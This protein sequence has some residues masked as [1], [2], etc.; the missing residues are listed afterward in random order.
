MT[1]QSNGPVANENYS[2]A[3]GSN[4]S[5]P[6]ITVLM[7]RDPNQYDSQYPVKQR[8]VNTV[9]ATEWILI[10]FSNVTGRTLANWLQLVG[11]EMA[12]TG[13]F[14]P[15][16]SLS[17]PGTSSFTYTLQ[18]GEFTTIGNIVVFSIRILLSNFTIGTG[19]GNVQ[20]GTLPFSSGASSVN[21]CFSC[22]LQNITFDPTVSWYTGLLQPGNNFIIFPG[23]VTAT[24]VSVLQAASL[25]NTS[26]IN[27]TGTYFTS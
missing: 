2:I 14:V 3:T 8:W 6:F 23:S 11:G 25:T 4:S 20:V 24:T 12:V 13:T 27:V 26:I 1:F 16:I 22:T 17:T 18:S 19:S 9:E 5:G 15:T 10:G 21:M 7:T